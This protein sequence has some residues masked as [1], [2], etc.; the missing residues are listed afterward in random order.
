MEVTMPVGGAGTLQA[1]P[2]NPEATGVSRKQAVAQKPA[3]S[4]KIAISPK[5]GAKRKSSEVAG[6]PETGAKRICLEL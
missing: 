2:T 3:R 5:I 1:C 6:S 4:P